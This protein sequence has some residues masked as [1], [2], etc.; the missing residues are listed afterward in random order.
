M[1]HPPVRMAFQLVKHGM[2]G[3]CHLFELIYGRE[4]SREE[5]AMQP[6]REVCTQSLILDNEIEQ[7][8]IRQQDMKNKE[9]KGGLII[10]SMDVHEKLFEMKYPK[11]ANAIVTLLTS[12]EY[13]KQIAESTDNNRNI[14]GEDPRESSQ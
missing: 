11:E 7:E 6:V 3:G 13:Y 14:P 9:G 8:F 12:K 5:I 4:F 2:A 10:G 1:R